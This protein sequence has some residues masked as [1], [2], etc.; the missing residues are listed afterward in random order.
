M[1]LSFYKILSSSD[2]LLFRKI[3]G[4]Q[5]YTLQSNTHIQAL[6][7]QKKMVKKFQNLSKIGEVLAI[8]TES[9]RC[10]LMILLIQSNLE[11]FSN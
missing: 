1:S 5:T 4:Y 10:M 3:M 11:N 2:T 6:L 9:L 7:T 8:L